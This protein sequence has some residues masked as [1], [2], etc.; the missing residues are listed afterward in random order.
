MAKSFEQ[1]VVQD[2]VDIKNQLGDYSDI[3]KVPKSFNENL[4][5]IHS[6][7]KIENY[8]IQ[9]SFIIGHLTLAQRDVTLLNV[10]YGEPELV[11]VIP[12]DNLFIEYF[13]N[14]VFINEN[15]SGIINN[16]NETYT[17]N[18]G[19]LLISNIVYKTDIIPKGVGI[20]EEFA[21]ISSTGSFRLDNSGLAPTPTSEGYDGLWGGTLF[22]VSGDN[23]ISW[24]EFYQSSGIKYFDNAT[25]EGVRYKLLA[26]DDLV[27]TNPIKLQIYT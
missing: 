1:N 25:V 10:E 23:G 26:F 14:E 27:I 7:S 20:K 18:S 2:K 13:S 3:Q 4:N 19:S 5:I 12:K 24:R 9:S 16:T 15:S 6:I 22:M 11:Y 21:D 8:P 17:L